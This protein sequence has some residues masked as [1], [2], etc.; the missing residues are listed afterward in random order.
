MRSLLH[1]AGYN[2]NEAPMTWWLLAPKH[3]GKNLEIPVPERA[4][5]LYGILGTTWRDQEG[6]PA[7]GNPAA[8]NVASK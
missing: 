6:V 7:P 4:A 1:D 3:P 8:G 2:L 5:Y